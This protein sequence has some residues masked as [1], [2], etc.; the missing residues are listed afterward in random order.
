MRCPNCENETQ[1][2]FFCYA[3]DVYLT[4]PSVGTKAGVARRFAAQLLDAVA[5]WVI[6]FAILFIS[7][8]VGSAGQTS[9]TGIGAFVGTFFW[10]MIGYTVFALWFLAQGKTPGKW[11]V[12]IRVVN[13]M[14]ANVPGLGRMLVREII[15]KFV[16]G[17][18]LGLGYFWAIFDREN[19][20]WHDKIAGTLVVRQSD[21]PQSHLQT[22]V[23]VARTK[24]TD[25][26]PAAPAITS[27]PSWAVRAPT[28]APT[29]APLASCFCSQC[30]AKNEVG[31]RFCE[32]CGAKLD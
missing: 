23:A 2:G 26:L 4:D 27:P 17:F 21:V 24:E 25:L 6:F 9:E 10:A 19:Q 8:S 5:G 28:I 3:C 29:A 12:G 22:Q 20:A 30:G 1:V 16:S 13:K 14:N 7:A 31:S 32:N 11:L 15:G 18:F